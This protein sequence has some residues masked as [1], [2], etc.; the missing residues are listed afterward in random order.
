MSSLPEVYFA[1]I[2]QLSFD[3]IDKLLNSF[4]VSFPFSYDLFVAKSDDLL[5]ET[6]SVFGNPHPPTTA[7]YE[8]D[9]RWSIYHPMLSYQM[10]EGGILTEC[11]RIGFKDPKDAMHFKLSMDL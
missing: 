5:Q 1:E 7:I 11:V 8:S 3:Q 6:Q 10:T 4:R 2:H 9:F